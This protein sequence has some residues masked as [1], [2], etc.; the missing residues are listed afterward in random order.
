MGEGQEMGWFLLPAE[1]SLCPPT[2]SN[3]AGS[4]FLSPGRAPGRGLPG[5][6]GSQD[7]CEPKINQVRSLH[8]RNKPEVASGPRI[9]AKLPFVGALASLPV[10]SP[11]Q[12]GLQ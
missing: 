5:G 12:E 7:Y 6:F 1:Q 8:Q 2:Y 4:C 11:A 10:P 9:S 3:S